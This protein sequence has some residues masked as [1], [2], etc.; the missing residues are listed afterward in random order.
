MLSL[1]DTHGMERVKMTHCV[2]VE[3]FL[4]D[5]VVHVRMV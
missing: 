1:G 5:I 2:Q 3:Q 4:N